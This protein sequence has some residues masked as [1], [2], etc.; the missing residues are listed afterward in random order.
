MQ[1]SYCIAG[2]ILRRGF[3]LSAFFS[4]VPV[5][6]IYSPSESL[7]QLSSCFAHSLCRLTHID[8]KPPNGCF[9]NGGAQ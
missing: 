1:K 3:S 2:I 4:Y 7:L 6:H 8:L 9:P 5:F